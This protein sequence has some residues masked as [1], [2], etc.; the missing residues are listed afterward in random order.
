MP[1]Q[2]SALERA[3][4]LM[5]ALDHELALESVEEAEGGDGD[6]AAPTNP[7]GRPPHQA[8][9]HGVQRA[10]QSPHLAHER[11]CTPHHAYRPALRSSTK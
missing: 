4:M 11:I 1:Q 9:A 8:R 5:S 10:L 7:L 3:G 2:L 6:A